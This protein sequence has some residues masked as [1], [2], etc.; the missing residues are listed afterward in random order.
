MKYGADLSTNVTKSPDGQEDL[1]EKDLLESVSDVLSKHVKEQPLNTHPPQFRI[2]VVGVT[3]TINAF[4][5]LLRKGTAKKVI[6]ISSGMGD[7]D[8]TSRTGISTQ[9]PYSISKAALNMVIVKY[10][11]QYKS[12]GF[13]FLAIS[14]GLVNTA[15]KARASIYSVSLIRGANTY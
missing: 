14:P 10:A 1:L 7:L 12:E 8:F 2:N 11:A 6:T 9:A 15:V 4:L 3:H 13:V 5:P